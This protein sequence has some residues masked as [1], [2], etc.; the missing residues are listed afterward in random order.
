MDRAV[1]ENGFYLVEVEVLERNR[2]QQQE[3]VMW[4]SEKPREE[5]LNFFFYFFYGL[6]PGKSLGDISKDVATVSKLQMEVLEIN[7]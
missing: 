1:P 4:F 2:Q 6:L 5:F 7:V 3:L